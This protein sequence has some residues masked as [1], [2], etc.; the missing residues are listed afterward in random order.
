MSISALIHYSNIGNL[1]SKGKCL[2]VRDIFQHSPKNTNNFLG[3]RRARAAL[4][5]PGGAGARALLG[6]SCL[7]LALLEGLG[8]AQR[9]LRA[10]R[11]LSSTKGLVGEAKGQIPGRDGGGSQRWAPL[12]L[13]SLCALRAFEL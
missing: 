1:R 3:R 13:E 12:S 9:C 10:L 4:P 5:G 2:G 11:V 6:C 8:S 7:P